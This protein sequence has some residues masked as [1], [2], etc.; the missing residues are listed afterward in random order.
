MADRKPAAKI[1][2]W[3]LSAAIWRNQSGEGKVFYS[4]TFQ[5]SYRDKDG[6]VQNSDSFDGTELLLL[7]K[8]ADLAHTKIHNLRSEDRAAQR[9]AGEAVEDDVAAQY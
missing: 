4:V 1:D 3:P 5:R 9:Q 7:A 8:V 6:K 2:M